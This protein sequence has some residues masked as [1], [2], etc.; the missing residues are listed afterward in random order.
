VGFNL[1]Q[2]HYTTRDSLSPS[3]ATMPEC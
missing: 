1:L 3:T 2:V